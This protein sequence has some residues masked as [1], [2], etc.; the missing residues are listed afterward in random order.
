MTNFPWYVVRVRSNFERVASV[1]FQEKGYETF[2]P[3]YLSRR[4]WSDRTKQVE[5]PLFSGY[6]FSRFDANLRLP[7]L[8][9]PGVV[10]IIGSSVTGPLP[11]D[12]AEIEAV[13]TLLSSKV[14][15]GPCPFLRV[16][17]AVILDRGP[18]AGVEGLVLQIKENFRLVVSISILQRSVYAE[19]DRDWIKP[20]KALGAS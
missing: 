6:V 16:G 12:E 19:I 18:L 9:T 13:R 3:V 15:V 17:Q 11:V 1:S 7:I 4:R 2:L 10:S 20:V 14:P 8:Q 5:L